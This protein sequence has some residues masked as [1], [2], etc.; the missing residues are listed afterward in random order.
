MAMDFGTKMGIQTSKRNET[1]MKNC[2]PSRISYLVALAV[3]LAAGLNVRAATNQVGFGSFFFN[4]KNI[5]INVGDTVLWKSSP[6]GGDHTVTGTGSDPICGNASLLTCSH[7]FDTPGTFPYQ[8]ILPGHAAAGMTGTITAVSAAT[9]V[10][11]TLM[12]RFFG[13]KKK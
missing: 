13:L 7:K 6:G 11:P 10:P 3:V 5:T 8:C 9:N 12:V 4:P 1:T 2:F